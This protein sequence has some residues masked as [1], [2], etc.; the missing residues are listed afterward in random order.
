MNGRP[1]SDKGA[2]GGGDV[3]RVAGRRSS[4]LR[5]RAAWMY[6]V[7]DMTQSAIAEALGIGRVTVVRL[8]ADA[9][10]L[11]EVKISLAR[12]IADLPRLEF[13]L[14]RAL[15]IGE[16]VVA[17]MAGPNSDP[18]AVVGAATGQVLMEIIRPG[19]R[20]G[21]GWGRTL[22]RALDVIDD[23]P[24]AGLDVVSLLGG[25]A[26]VKQY[27]PAE[28]AW[29]FAS[30]FHADCYLIAA[31][32]LVDSAETRRALVERCGIGQILD[33]A[34]RLD[35]VVASIGSVKETSTS[36]R[37]GYVSEEER[38]SLIAIGAVGDV[39]YRYF[40]IHGNPVVHPIDERVMGVGYKDLAAAPIRVLSSG[41]L[42]KIEAIIGAA[43]LFKPTTLVTDEVTANAIL[44]YLTAA[45]EMPEP[46]PAPKD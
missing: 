18:I 33:M 44:D 14:E 12:D 16:A 25:I 45:G 43:R 19:M 41:G 2:D 24:M 31:P 22:M 37:F 17:P 28:F 9:R 34:E 39:L 42:D 36:Y 20:I 40:D 27:N 7:E 10:A 38:A 4:R 35:A 32:A 1:G 5:L 46:L 21:V 15:G 3:E 13:G 6:Y 29:R 30:T 23:R 26:F 8:L 11:Q